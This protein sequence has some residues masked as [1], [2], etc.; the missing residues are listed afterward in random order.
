VKTIVL[1]KTCIGKWALGLSIAF[2]V[3]IAM[4][5][6]GSLP[7]PTFTITALGLTGFAMGIV[8]ILRNRD[9]GILNYM[10]ITVGVVIIA[11]IATELILRH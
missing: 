9:R 2:I 11:W 4:K 7:M 10:A 8:A 3:L 5:I 1:P 6:Q